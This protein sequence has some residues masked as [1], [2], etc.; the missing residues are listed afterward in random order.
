M[1]SKYKIFTFGE[2]HVYEL[3][4]TL[5]KVLRKEHTIDGNNDYL[6]VS[7]LLSLA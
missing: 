4:K 1:K 7:E 5:A 3:M 6:L 2:L